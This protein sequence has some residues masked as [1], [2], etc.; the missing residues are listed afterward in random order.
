MEQFR[1]FLAL[2]YDYE[3]LEKDLLSK[4]R[5]E[6]LVAFIDRRSRLFSDSLSFA[7]WN[8]EDSFEKGNE[9]KSILQKRLYNSEILMIADN[10]K[11]V[12][13]KSD[14]VMNHSNTV[15]VVVHK[16]KEEVWKGKLTLN[17][18]FYDD[19]V[20]KISSN[21]SEYASCFLID[22]VT[23]RELYKL[24]GNIVSPKSLSLVGGVP[25]D[26]R[27]N[28]Y[29]KGYCPTGISLNDTELK[30]SDIINVNG[31]DCSVGEFFERL[32]HVER[33][34][35]EVTKCGRKI[36]FSIL[37]RQVT[38]E[39]REYGYS[40]EDG[41]LSPFADLIEPD[42]PALVGPLIRYDQFL[43]SNLSE[44]TLPILV[45]ILDS[46]AN[47]EELDHSEVEAL[48]RF[49]ERVNINSNLKKFAIQKVTRFKK[50]RS[51]PSIFNYLGRSA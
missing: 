30:K 43:E 41:K 33:H 14:L 29:L 49:L 26:A 3:M 15:L 31:D 23:E 46:T 38:E 32:N 40:I 34:S 10:R 24:F 48:I 5:R 8:G 4:G 17:Q 36:G 11:Y 25:V 47:D 21:I 18:S 2:D 28:I 13:M 42:I 51:N 35:F 50:I 44:I 39:S 22:R 19:K 45:S 6:I 20:E 9:L 12:E 1:S 27:E 7:I 37:T 16:D